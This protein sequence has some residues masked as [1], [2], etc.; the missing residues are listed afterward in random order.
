[1]TFRQIIHI[2][3]DA[4]FASVEQLDFPE[5]K[6]KPVAVGGKSDR[7][8]IA[9][10][11]YEARKYGVKSAM[12]TH[13]A[14]QKCPQ[15][16]IQPARF[17][18]YKSLSREVYQVYQMV[19]DDIEPLSIDEAFLDVTENKL[20]WIDAVD[21]AKHIKN[22]IKKATGLIASAGVSHNKF[23]AKMASDIDKPDGLFA[24]RPDQVSEVL[25]S[26]P[27]QR[28]FGIGKVT[29]GRMNEMGIFT[30]KDLKKFSKEDLLRYFGNQGSWYYRI[31]RGIDARPLNKSRKSKSIGVERTL[32]NAVEELPEAWEKSQQ[33]L[34]QLWDRTAVRGHFGRTLTLKIKFKNRKHITRSQ[35]FEHQ[36]LVRKQLVEGARL[37]LEQLYP[38]DYS[39][40]LIGFTLSNFSNPK[41]EAQLRLFT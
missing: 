34:D 24:I 5:L 23:L 21:V 4:F 1:M 12:P 9:A 7:G 10:S 19:T 29:S 22:E 32:S 13:E 25:D 11:S 17:D 38:F 40:R 2:D 20:G 8:V 3:M 30:G 39:I 35:T 36:L 6:G 18:R 27:V 14:L 37:L 16:I 15:L 31:A 26:M 28:F 33:I 41:K